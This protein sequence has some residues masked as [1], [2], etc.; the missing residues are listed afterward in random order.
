MTEERLL[1][2]KIAS[3]LLQYPDAGLLDTFESLTEV[4]QELPP[5]PAREI[6]ADFLRHF[7][8]RRL[9]TW[10]EEYTRHF[11]LNPATSLNLTYHRYGDGKER[12]PA[13]AHLHQVY[14]GA[15]YEA[16]TCELPDFLPLVL[17]FL[18]ICPEEEYSWLLK[19]YRFQIETLA[20]RLKET[21]TP[22]AN[23]LSV[24]VDTFRIDPA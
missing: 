1:V 16:A 3:H 4:M 5:G 15:G 14:Q 22:Y 12:G 20:N 6:F 19:E 24:L 10:Q 23:L 9:L 21:G 8:D 11:D 18:A 17:E 7:S 2:L 13:L